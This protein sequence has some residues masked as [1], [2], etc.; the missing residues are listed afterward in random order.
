MRGESFTCLSHVEIICGGNVDK[1][2]GWFVQPTIAV[3]SNPKHKLMAEEL[4][5][6]VLAI[7]VYD[8]AKVPTSAMLLTCS[9]KRHWTCAIPLPLTP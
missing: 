8:D 1:S 9:L 6:P 4:F 5:A 3:V 7:Y 2:V